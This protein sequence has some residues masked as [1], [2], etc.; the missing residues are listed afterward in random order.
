M[1]EINFSIYGD[2]PSPLEGSLLQEFQAQHRVQVRVSRMLWNDAW[3]K[4]LNFAVYGGGPD[5]SQIGAIWTSTLVSMNALR[6]FTAQEIN[7][8]GGTES[9]FAPTWQSTIP[10][11][12]SEVWGIPFTA[13]TYIVL[14]RRDLLQRAGIAEETAFESAAAMAETL[15]RLRAAGVQ[16]PWVAPSGQSYRARVHIAASWIWGAGG[17]FVSDD[18]RRILFDQ[19]EARAGIK[20]FFELYRYLSSS[21]YNLTH[22]ECLRR[23]ASGDAAVTITGSNLPSALKSWTVSQVVENLGTAVVPGVPW[24]GGSNIVIWREAQ[25]RPERERAAVLLANFLASQ[26]TQIKYAAVSDSIPARSNALPYLKFEPVSLSQ[27]FEQ[28]LRTGRSYKPTL[29]WV[30]LLNDLSR[31]FD[32]ITADI[33]ADPPLDVAHALSGRL[34]PLAR[35]FDLMLSG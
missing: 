23:F 28:A 35:R 20:A 8:L 6:P 11:G 2:L 17:D 14:Y 3:P 1:T 18:G 13:F 16:S 9:F 21:D 34:D 32:M 24:V 31:T 10:L 33:L 19:P 5:I 29:I 7:G 30:R 12:R 26:S 27:T 15:E 22:D 25:V 4:L